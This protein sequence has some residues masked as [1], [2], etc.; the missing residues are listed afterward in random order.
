MT[1]PAS[2]PAMAMAILLLA[3]AALFAIGVG[4]ERAT[5]TREPKPAATSA[6]GNHGEEPAQ[7][8][9]ANGENHEPATGEHAPGH[10]ETA[11]GERVL[12]VQADSAAAVGAMLIAS[13][14]VA[15]ALRLRP[16]RA[17][18]AAAGA[19]AATAAVFDIAE[20][21]HQ[22]TEGRTSVL[23]I[24]AVVAAIHLAVV[25]VALAALGRRQPATLTAA[26]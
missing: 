15:T 25:T 19:F 13:A 23:L 2:R 22:H 11:A 3:A 4:L 21:A 9:A 8:Q 24:A 7:E 12:G 6:T 17:V 18:L 20:T 14:L 10:V 26:R 5:K 16:S 1:R